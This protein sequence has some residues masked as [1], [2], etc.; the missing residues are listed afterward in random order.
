[1]YLESK[2]RDCFKTKQITPLQ[3]QSVK[4]NERNFSLL[5]TLRDVD[6]KISGK[7]FSIYWF[8]PFLGHT[9]TKTQAKSQPVLSYSFAFLQQD[10]RLSD[11]LSGLS[12]H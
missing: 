11:I 5:G 6:S 10:A 3:L 8:D 9:Q 12:S 7:L 1:M 2:L 4:S